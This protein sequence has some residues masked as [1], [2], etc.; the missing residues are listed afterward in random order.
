MLKTSLIKFIFT[1]ILLDEGINTCIDLLFKENNIV[2][3]LNKR[4]M[5]EMLLVTLK[6]SII[7]FNN[8]YYSQVDGNG[9][10][11]LLGLTLRN[12]LL[13]RHEAIWFKRCLKEFRAKYYK[14]FFG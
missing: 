4:Q 14:I 12:I 1:N 13:Y 10:G 2:S 11:F 8:K 3:G 7:L 9:Y 5:L 6:G